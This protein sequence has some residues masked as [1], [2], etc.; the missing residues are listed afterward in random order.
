M[1]VFNL[2]LP[3]A[4][5]ALLE[6]FQGIQ[7]FAGRLLAFART[8]QLTSPDAFHDP[9]VALELLALAATFRR[10]S[11]VPPVLAA[12]DAVDPPLVPR[13]CAAAAADGP[14]RMLPVTTPGSTWS[15]SGWG[16]YDGAGASAGPASDAAVVATTP[17]ANSLA[18]TEFGWGSP[19]D[20]Y[21]Q[22]VGSRAASFF[23]A[24]DIF[25]G[26]SAET[27]P[28]DGGT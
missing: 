14:A 17:A 25:A 20:A 2:T 9:T 5:K 1:P 21:G 22:C 23:D 12:L 24:D 4:V 13:P 3:R 15:V 16:S 8:A 28:A 19:A 26:E 27:A 11:A 7:R 6:R 10:L 18:G